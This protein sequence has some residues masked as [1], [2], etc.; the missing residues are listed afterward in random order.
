[1]EPLEAESYSEI[2]ARFRTEYGQ[3]IKNYNEEAAAKLARGV[4]PDLAG[5][6]QAREMIVQETRNRLNES[7]SPGALER[8]NAFVQ[9]EKKHMTVPLSNAERKGGAAQ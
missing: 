3:L 4:T 7:L 2:L 9:N 8:L 1:L 6:L 5:F